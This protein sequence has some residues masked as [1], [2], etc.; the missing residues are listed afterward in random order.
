M[1]LLTGQGDD[2]I[3]LEAAALGITDYITKQDLDARGLERSIRYAISQ[4]K[5]LNELAQT[6]RLESLGQLAGGIA[7]DFNNLLG[8]ILLHVNLVLE[9]IADA[10]TRADLEQIRAATEQGARLTRQLLIFGRRQALHPEY[11]DLDSIVEDVHALL[12][13]SLGEHVELIVRSEPALPA[14]RADRGQI[15]QILINLAVNARDA[16]PSGGTLTI[17]TAPAKLDATHGHLNPSVAPGHYVE[18]RVSDNGVGMTEDVK[19]RIFEPFFTT[20]PTG[21]GTGLGLATVYGIVTE[22]GGGIDVDSETG[23]GTTFRVYLPA[24]AQ[25]AVADAHADAEAPAG[26]GETILVVEDEPAMLALI[27]RILRSSG[28]HVLDASTAE[29]ALSLASDHDFELLLTD[30]VM[31]VMSGRQLTE[32]IRDIRP[33]RP[34]LF[35][36]GYNEDSLSRHQVVEAGVALLQKPFN[37]DT[38]LTRVRDALAAAGDASR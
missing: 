18:V 24:S 36:S 1:I 2:E 37:R 38:L 26:R 19:A 34:V 35:M 28:Y 11:L 5:T 8:V 30:S 4:H 9:D 21:E 29:K 3:D 20:K 33:G 17:E 16:M 7:H 32:E 10:G 22:A 14:V 13:R 23:V 31:P 6:Q 25:K 27:A 15:E 12:S